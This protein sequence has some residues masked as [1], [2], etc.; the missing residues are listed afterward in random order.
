MQHLKKLGN[1]VVR[2]TI[3]LSIQGFIT[4]E[5]LGNWLVIF[6]L[7][8]VWQVLNIQQEWNLNFLL[9]PLITIYI[10]TDVLMD[11]ALGLCWALSKLQWYG[12]IPTN[13]RATKYFFRTCNVLPFICTHLALWGKL[14]DPRYNDSV[15]A[16]QKWFKNFFTCHRMF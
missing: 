7:L 5:N 3:L 11:S 1:N 4:W 9:T 15:H 6:M 16:K 2:L 13:A 14:K 12:I 8:I 10:V